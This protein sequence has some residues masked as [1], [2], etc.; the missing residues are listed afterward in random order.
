MMIN[1]LTPLHLSL[2]EEVIMYIAA[3]ELFDM[4]EFYDWLFGFNEDEHIAESLIFQKAGYPT[5]YFVPS[6]GFLGFTFFVVPPT[7]GLLALIN[8]CLK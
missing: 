1:V 6:F 5:L 4:D 8:C 7:I 3:I 2:F